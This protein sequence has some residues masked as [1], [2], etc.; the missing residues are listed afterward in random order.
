MQVRMSPKTSIDY[1]W[2][3]AQQRFNGRE[4]DAAQAACESILAQLPEHSG[5]RLMLAD[6]CNRRGEHRQ[7]T[8]HIIAAAART[9]GQA[10]QTNVAITWKLISVGEYEQ[11]LRLIR[12][13]DLSAAGAAA[14]LADISQQLSLLRQH[15]DALRYLDAAITRGINDASVRYLRGNYLRFL[16]RLEQSAAE[17]ERCIAISPRFSYAHWA[18]AYL[19]HGPDR[20][21]RVDRLRHVLRSG[22]I[23]DRDR[24][25][26]SYALFKELDALND[27]DAAWRALMDGAS[28]KRR[29][30]EY[31]SKEE[32]LLIDEL[33]SACQGGSIRQDSP[34]VS[35]KIPIFVLG[36]PRTGT[37][38]VERILGGHPQVTSCGELNDFHKQYKWVSDHSCSGIID[39]IGVARRRSVDFGELGNRYVKHVTWR[40]PNTRYFTDKNPGNWMMVGFILKALPQARI[41]RLRRQAMDTCFSNLKELFASK[42]YPY[43]YRLDDLASHYRNYTRLMSHWHDVAP[44]RI[45]DVSYEDLISNPEQEARRLMD[46]CGLDFRSSQLRIEANSAPVATASSAQVRRAIHGRHIGGWKR[47]ANQLATIERDLVGQ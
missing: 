45:L 1:A 5:A 8:G 18:L 46:Y 23:E 43:S 34:G 37:T 10:L 15:E 32:T 4:L 42:F 19:D 16:G 3:K 29:T 35:D 31:D 36:M 21:R 2:R 26:L 47:Y 28:A 20:G 41:V 33:I 22:A 39:R 40:A 12:N 17:Y 27:T 11:A 38:V 9:G 25:Y 44:D 6:I 24:A 13:M 7:A 30:L 14:L